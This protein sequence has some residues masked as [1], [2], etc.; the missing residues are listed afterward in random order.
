MSYV[1]YKKK[2]HIVTI[3]LNR[4]ERLNALGKEVTD[5]IVDACKRV[6]SDPEVRVAILT[7]TGRAFCA[8]NDVHEMHEVG[9][10]PNPVH[11]AYVVA[12]VT[13][14]VIAAVNGFALGGGCWI[15]I[16]C[17][18][19]IAV[20]S[21]TFGMP[22]I[23]VA[24]PLGPERYIMQQIPLCIINEMIF[25]GEPISAQRAYE[26]GLINKVVAEEDLIAEAG[27]VAERIAG[28][29]PWAIQI[30][31]KA[32]IKASSLSKETFDEEQHRRIIARQADDFKE[33]VK[34]FAEKRKPIFK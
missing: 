26:V 23:K 13:K 6:D 20:K 19:R 21:A 29:S 4:P 12:E 17:D 31:K 2:G 32:K 1:E 15:A 28:L 34:A 25:L 14:P 33:A 30:N 9:G 16:A 7:G 11:A 27:K 10:P 3:T 5:E 18:I 22:E 24:I 8:G